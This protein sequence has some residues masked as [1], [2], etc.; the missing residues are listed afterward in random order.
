MSGAIDTAPKRAI[1][2]LAQYL[3]R[4]GVGL[5]GAVSA[6]GCVAALHTAGLMVIE[7]EEYA[8]LIG[9]ER[10]QRLREVGGD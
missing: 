1:E 5:G 9:A 2:V 3:S 6:R 4:M 8:A 10:Q 7:S